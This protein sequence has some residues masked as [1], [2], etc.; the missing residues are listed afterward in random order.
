MMLAGIAVDAVFDSVSVVTTF[1]DKLAEAE[2]IFCL[3][4]ALKEYP[5]LVRK[6]L[7]SVVPVRDNYR[8]LNCAVFSVSFVYIP[9]VRCPWSCPPT[10]ASTQKTRGSLTHPH[11]PDEAACVLPRGLHGAAR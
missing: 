7:G 2:V 8:G 5:E 11:R 1:K 9:R 3:S 6:H 4:E 10:S